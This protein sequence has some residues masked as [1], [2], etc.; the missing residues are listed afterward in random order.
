VNKLLPRIVVGVCLAVLAVGG[1]VAWLLRD[2]LS[3][4]SK[5]VP[6]RADYDA[7]VARL[8]AEE[9]AVRDE[10]NALICTA[11]G[12]DETDQARRGTLTRDCPDPIVLLEI[13]HVRS[14]L[15]KAARGEAD[16][17][18]FVA[19]DQRGHL[20]Q[21]FGENP[22]AEEVLAVRRAL[23]RLG[24]E[25]EIIRQPPDWKVKIE[26]EPVAMPFLD[27]LREGYE[28]MPATKHPPL[29]AEPIIPAFAGTDAELLAHID[30]YFNGARARA[31][32]PPEKFPKLYEGGR[33]PPIPTALADYRQSIQAGIA[34]EKRILLPSANPGPDA[35]EAVND[36]YDKL[37]R[38][39]AAVEQFGD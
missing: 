37:E 24:A 20:K 8:G 18:H 29:R 32:F 36:V 28:F 33:I 17:F 25:F 2:R 23:A 11:G 5:S 27:L 7:L 12:L 34:A 19:P 21:L 35:I 15:R 9:P 14:Y 16:P 1:T 39:F 38:F 13:D 30:Q 6:D 4:S 26:G 3:A 22:S 10:L 31:A